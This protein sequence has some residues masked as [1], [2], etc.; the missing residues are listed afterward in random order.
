[1]KR[2]ILLVRLAQLTLAGALYLCAGR[3]TA[4]DF[5]LVPR[6]PAPGHRLL[7]YWWNFN[8]GAWELTPPEGFTLLGGGELRLLKTAEPDLVAICRP[9]TDAE[10]A[11]LSNGDQKAQADYVRKML[12]GGITDI[13]LLSQAKNPLPVNGLT[14]FEVS[15]SYVL[16]GIP[17]RLS[18]LVSQGGEM[19]EQS[20]P[21]PG[22]PTPPPTPTPTPSADG[23]PVRTGEF[24]TAVVV[25]PADRQPAVYGAFKQLLA[26]ARIK[27]GEPGGNDPDHY[28][29]HGMLGR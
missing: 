20:P 15:Y 13:K 28:S 21:V 3:A 16:G 26:T 8:H 17:C 6:E 22:Q 27:P 1:M 19:L 9:T 11:L 2:S 14:N 24:F 4:T 5:S 18:Y 10:R 7:S 25:A 12:P 29:S 23:K